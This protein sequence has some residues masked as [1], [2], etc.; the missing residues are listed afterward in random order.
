[1]RG[2]WGFRHIVEQLVGTQPPLDDV[3]GKISKLPTIPPVRFIRTVADPYVQAL[4]NDFSTSPF[5]TSVKEYSV[6]ECFLDPLRDPAQRPAVVLYLGHQIIEG[7]AEAP[8][9]S[10]LAADKS[11]LLRLSDITHEILKPGKWSSPRSIVILLGCATGSDRMDT[12]I[13]LSGGLLNL[14]AGG[15]VATECI[16][17]TDIVA[18]M[19]RDLT[20][21]LLSGK[22]MGDSMKNCTWALAQEGC[23]MGLVFT[24]LGPAEAALPK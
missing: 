21:E 2:F 10:L 9:T 18:R 20:R 3:P 15:V 19:A 23:P 4:V 1:L 11:I 16:V 22:S 7:P 24:Y 8:E 13:G 5:D 12:G 14:G 17:F 6:P